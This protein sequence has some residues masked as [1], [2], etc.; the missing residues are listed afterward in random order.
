MQDFRNLV[1][2]QKAHALTLAIYRHNRIS[3]VTSCMS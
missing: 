3:L 2:W 1:V